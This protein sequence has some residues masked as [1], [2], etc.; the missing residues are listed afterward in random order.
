[1]KYKKIVLALLVMMIVGSNS[2]VYANEGK[3]KY[4]QNQNHAQSQNLP[5][6]YKKA[7][8]D[9]PEVIINTLAALGISEQNLKQAIEQGKKV[10]EI[11]QEQGITLEAF[12]KALTQEYA[13]RIKQ[14]TKEEVITKK[15]AKTLTKLLKERMD[16]WEV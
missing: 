10:Y 11:L 5:Q 14:A 8:L 16:T 15:E 2:F 6:L 7:G 9:K 4:V 12:K 3:T 13:I 1:M